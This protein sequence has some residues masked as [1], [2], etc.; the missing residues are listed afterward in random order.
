M[1]GLTLG[2]RLHEAT[3]L[4]IAVALGGSFAGYA[5]AIVSDLPVSH[6]I[7][8]VLGLTFVAIQPTRGAGFFA[9][10]ARGLI[11]A[12]GLGGVG[13]GVW[14]LPGLVAS[15]GGTP[16]ISSTGHG[17]H[18]AGSATPPSTAE[19]VAQAIG[20]LR[21]DGTVEERTLA[22][23]TLGELGGPDSLPTLLPAL[24]DENPTVHDAVVHSVRAFTER[25]G[26]SRMRVL[27]RGP[28]AELAAHASRALVIVGDELAL[29]FLVAFLERED[30][31]L[32]LRDEL[33]TELRDATGQSFGYDAFAAPK[34]NTDAIAQWWAW[35]E[36][37][38][39]E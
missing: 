30:A 19:R 29:G 26:T 11:L 2:R 13:I 15:I 16:S 39:P 33:L 10:I 7:A 12:A 8:A 25:R 27:A 21:G 20:H 6:S 32:L 34:E 37:N 31:P 36:A 22:A 5:F 3:V 14:L 17:H 23:A 35:W 18:H 24:A 4:S 1:I 9:H 38:R 28:E